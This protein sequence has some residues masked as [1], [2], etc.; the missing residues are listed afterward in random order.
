MGGRYQSC[1]PQDTK[2]VVPPRRGVRVMKTITLTK[3]QRGLL[4]LFD[5][6]AHQNL[7]VRT[8]G[9]REFVVAEIDDFDREI[10]LARRYKKL[11]ALL[12]RRGLQPATIP[13]ETVRKR[14]GLK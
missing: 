14:L 3:Q 1:R 2:P 5:L 4:G 8:P 9:G 11:M 10:E 12:D 13:I 7:A 6:A